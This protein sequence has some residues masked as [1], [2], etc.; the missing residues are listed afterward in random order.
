[1][2]SIKQSCN[3]QLPRGLGT[4]INFLP[5]FNAYIFVQVFNPNHAPPVCVHKPPFNFTHRK[6]SVVSAD[7]IQN[8]THSDNMAVPV[9]FEKCDM[10]VTTDK[11][12]EPPHYMYAVQNSIRESDDVPMIPGSSTECNIPE[13]SV[14]L[15]AM[16][17]DPHSGSTM[18]LTSEAETR[19][20]T[21][22]DSL[23]AQNSTLM[24]D[25]SVDTVEYGDT[26]QLELTSVSYQT[27][28]TG[29]VGDDN[30]IDR[31][32]PF[33]ASDYQPSKFNQSSF[34]TSRPGDM[35]QLDQSANVECS[36]VDSLS[37]STNY[38]VLTPQENHQGQQ[39]SFASHLDTN[40]MLDNFEDNTM[41]VLDAIDT[42]ESPISGR[43]PPTSS[44]NDQFNIV[45]G[46]DEELDMD[47][48]GNTGQLPPTST[49]D[50]DDIIELDSAVA[51]SSTL[52]VTASQ[53]DES[54]A[55]SLDSDRGSVLSLDLTGDI[56]E[57]L[58]YLD[59]LEMNQNRTLSDNGYL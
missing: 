26:L 56:P 28:A 25:N 33:T 53:D 36:G 43:L 49:R 35:I 9:S 14:E 15:P 10:T 37:Q 29:T 17:F 47:G 7:L 40:I 30:V 21:T 46:C 23:N 19:E 22:Y 6:I 34:V 1:M 42:S 16:S 3:F 54:C 27:P 11:S 31:K 48:C 12:G 50:S 39:T 45:N 2:S 24:Q 32:E 18:Q 55:L 4:P 58:K 51:N 38:I 59:Q 20:S 57:A 44:T 5:K 13:Q 41:N 52:V 8:L